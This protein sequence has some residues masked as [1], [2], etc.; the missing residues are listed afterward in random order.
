MVL[1]GP[2]H[3]LTGAVFV[4]NTGENP[5][6]VAGAIV[7]RADAPDVIGAASAVVAAG[8]T[9]AVTVSTV[10]GA[11]TPPGDY[12]VELELGGAPRPAVLRVEPNLAISVS[13]ATILATAG[14]QKVT[15]TLTNTGNLPLTLAPVT[16]ARTYD[17]GEDPGPDVTLTV[18]NPATIEPGD[19]M[20]VG[21]EVAVPVL[22]PTRR[23]QAKLPIGLSTLTIHIL[24]TT[25]PAS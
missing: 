8:Q 5:L 19:R 23:H 12:P 14:E 3:R 16:R 15:L 24:P 25:E 21:A 18:P 6:T 20:E 11:H 9:T 13:P 7:R 1:S 4:A 10:L 2:P 22:D 17:G